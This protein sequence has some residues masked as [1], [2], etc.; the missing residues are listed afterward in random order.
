MARYIQARPYGRLTITGHLYAHKEALILLGAFIAL[1]L[2]ETIADGV[3]L[4]LGFLFN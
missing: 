1:A 2:A 3:V 4:V